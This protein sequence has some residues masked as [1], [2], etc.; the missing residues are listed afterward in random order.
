MPNFIEIRVPV[1][2][3]TELLYF[4]ILVLICKVLLPSFRFSLPGK[5]IINRFVNQQSAQIQSKW[6]QF[7]RPERRSLVRGMI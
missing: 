7:E 4:I 3:D 1:L 5:K 2:S 6:M